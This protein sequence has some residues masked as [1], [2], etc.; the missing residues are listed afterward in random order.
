[1]LSPSRARSLTL[2]PAKS[3]VG[4]DFEPSAGPVGWNLTSLYHNAIDA[5]VCQMIK[6]KANCFELN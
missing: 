3:P 6:D 4:P 5:Y 1:M 2:G